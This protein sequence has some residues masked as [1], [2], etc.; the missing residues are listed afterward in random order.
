MLFD[1]KVIGRSPGLEARTARAGS[2]L[3]E[4]VIPASTWDS[5]TIPEPGWSLPAFEAQNVYDARGNATSHLGKTY[6]FD[7]EDELAGPTSATTSGATRPASTRP[8]PAVAT[9]ATA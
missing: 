6:T 8:R 9:A 4:V 3:K 7:A 1:R 5:Q 2:R